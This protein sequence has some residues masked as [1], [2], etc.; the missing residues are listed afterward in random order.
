MKKIFTLLFFVIM[1]QI[2]MN[3][4]NDTLAMWS[5]PNNDLADTLPDVH[6]EAN[7]NSFI[8][9]EGAS[10]IA[11]KNGLSTKAAQ[12]T[13]WQEGAEAKSWQIKI[14]TLA[15]KTLDLSVK[16]TAGETNPGPRDFKTQYRIGTAGEW[17]DIEGGELTVYNDWTSGVLDQLPLPEACQNI[18]E[19]YIRFVMTSNTAQDGSEVLETG[20]S[21]VDDLLVSGILY[22]GLDLISNKE[23]RV[24]P[25]PSHGTFIIETQDQ[26]QSL[27][28]YSMT[29]QLVYVQESINTNIQIDL[30][31]PKGSYFV[32][33]TYDNK[34][35]RIN[36]IIIR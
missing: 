28:I 34:E 18:E 11:M 15:Y 33:A 6:N 21:K 20:T 31:V 26:I 29:G 5:F 14:S 25:N 1:I 17:T 8:F 9:T 10:A 2:T 7:I 36:R 27:K 23:N 22:S 3:A 13:E 24:Y 30:A 32:E 4:Q 16:I 19:L 12:A 35:V